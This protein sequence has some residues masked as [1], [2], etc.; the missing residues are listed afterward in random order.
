MK[1]GTINFNIPVPQYHIFDPVASRVTRQTLASMGDFKRNF[2][3]SD[4]DSWGLA[5]RVYKYTQG[6]RIRY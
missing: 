6:A 1:G 4:L 5:F 3:N 2:N